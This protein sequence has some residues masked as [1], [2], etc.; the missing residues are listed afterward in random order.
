MHEVNEEARFLTV[1]NGAIH[2]PILNVV[3]MLT[4]N[5]PGDHDRG[6]RSASEVG[7][8]YNQPTKKQR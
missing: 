6:G 3:T 1:R 2:S 5:H 8:A 7:I 4:P